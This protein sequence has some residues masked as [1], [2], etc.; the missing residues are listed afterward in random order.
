MIERTCDLLCIGGGGAGITAAIVASEKGADV[1]IISKDHIGYGNTRII[2][3]VMA[4]G[5]LDPSREGEDFFKDIIVGGEFL[6]NQRLCRIN[7]VK[8]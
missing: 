2:G 3:G 4:Y 1:L 5:D 6:N 8:K 7:L